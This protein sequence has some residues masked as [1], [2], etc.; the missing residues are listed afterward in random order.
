M[1]EAVLSIIFQWAVTLQP[2]VKLFWVTIVK[3]HYETPLLSSP[4]N[5]ESQN[6]AE[7]LSSY[8]N[9]PSSV[10]V[11]S[12][13]RSYLCFARKFSEKRKP[14]HLMRIGAE[15]PTERGRCSGHA[16]VRGKLS[17]EPATLSSMNLTEPDTWHILMVPWLCSCRS[18]KRRKEG[19]M[20]YLPTSS[21]SLSR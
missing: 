12:S 18:W 20:T 15:I 3:T 17:G 1:K 13:Q 7:I 4:C 9:Q 5:Y 16:I 6:D 8:W 19:L 2:G 11:S 21:M 10:Q 14:Y